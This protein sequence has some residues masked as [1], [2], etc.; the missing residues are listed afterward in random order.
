MTE[1]SP[2]PAEHS[3][4]PLNIALWVAVVLTAVAAI[5]LG[6]TM[7]DQHDRAQAPV[8]DAGTDVGSGVVSAMGESPS[9]DQERIAEVL[10]QGALFVNAF[11]SFDYRRMD[12]DI[13]AVRSMG[14]PAFV[15]QYDKSTPGLKKL[16]AHLHSVGS[17]NVVWAAYEVGDADSATV[18]LASIGSV[19]NNLSKGPTARYVRTKLDLVKVDGRWLANSVEQI[20]AGS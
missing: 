14:T 18:L 20:G 1:A 19:T 7:Y 2:T 16:A 11:Q 13:A 4:I 5:F 15:K 12:S 17:S 9:V 8:V 6:K 3:R 10:K